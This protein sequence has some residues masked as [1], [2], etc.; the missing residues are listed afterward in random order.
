MTAQC[1][2]AGLFPVA[3]PKDNRTEEPWNVGSW[4]PIPIQTAPYDK[5]EVNTT[6]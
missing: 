2:L 6:C 1:V 3:K 5:D 4:Q